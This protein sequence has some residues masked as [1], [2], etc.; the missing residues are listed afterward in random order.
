MK[1]ETC[2]LHRF[3]KVPLTKLSTQKT[4]KILNFIKVLDEIPYAT[5]IPVINAR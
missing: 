5:V 1:R 3:D 2:D 4:E